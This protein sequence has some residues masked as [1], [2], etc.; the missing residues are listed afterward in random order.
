MKTATAGLGSIVAL[1]KLHCEARWLGLPVCT[2]SRPKT[3]K[4]AQASPYLQN[5]PKFSN[6]IILDTLKP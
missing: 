1:H 5:L 2:K 4:I 6:M 3:R